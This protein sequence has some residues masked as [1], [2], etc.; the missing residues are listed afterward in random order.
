MSIAK[1]VM[2]TEIP[3][4]SQ[5]IKTADPGQK[6]ASSSPSKSIGFKFNKSRRDSPNNENSPGSSTPRKK[7]ERLNYKNGIDILEIYKQKCLL[8]ND[9]NKINVEN[10]ADNNT[11]I[12]IINASNL[13]ALGYEIVEI[14]DTDLRSNLQS[15]TENDDDEDED[16]KSLEK[17]LSELKESKEKQEQQKKLD[18]SSRG[19]PSS[20]KSKLVIVRKEELDKKKSSTKKNKIIFV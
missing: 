4:R 6:S 16:E 5:S 20:D 1:E 9:V 18:D 10:N 11:N 2:V 13:N 8:K 3:A 17:I 19:S 15:T 7:L 14:K 12:K